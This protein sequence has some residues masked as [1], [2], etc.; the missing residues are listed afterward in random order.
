M[1]NTIDLTDGRVFRDKPE[2]KHNP[3]WSNYG[4]R[5]PLYY[6]S[7]PV[8][9]KKEEYGFEYNASDDIL[10]FRSIVNSDLDEWTEYNIIDSD[11]NSTYLTSGSQSANYTI[12]INRINSTDIRHRRRNRIQ[13]VYNENQ[14]GEWKNIQWNLD[15][16]NKN[17]VSNVLQV[18]NAKRYISDIFNTPIKDKRYDLF[19]VSSFEKKYRTLKGCMRCDFYVP[20]LDKPMDSGSSEYPFQTPEYTSDDERTVPLLFER[21]RPSISDLWKNYKRGEKNP[22]NSWNLDPDFLDE[23]IKMPRD[24]TFMDLIGRPEDVIRGIN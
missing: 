2:E 17:D 8:N 12:N 18:L 23:E 20:D 14:L 13:F 3:L 22:L 6:N 21:R 11:L 5:F 10:Y 7:K 4:T 1:K 24:S 16:Q 9:V 15:L 19:Y